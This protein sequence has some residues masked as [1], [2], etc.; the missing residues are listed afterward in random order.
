MGKISKTQIVITSSLSVVVILSL[1]IFILKLTTIDHNL[2]KTS[3]KLVSW[4]N[5]VATNYPLKN[6]SITANFDKNIL[7]GSA[8]CN[9]YFANFKIKGSKLTVNTSSM[10]RRLCSEMLMLQERD[11]LN[12]LENAQSYQINSSGE[13]QI[14]YKDKQSFGVMIFISQN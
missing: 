2:D 7:M 6:S 14:S 4:S 8:G 5:S 12:A 1:A 3:W 11:Y 13:L 10:S 9:Q